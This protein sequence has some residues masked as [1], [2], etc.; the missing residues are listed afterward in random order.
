[1]SVE[2]SLGG[3]GHDALATNKL[4]EACM[5][6]GHGESSLVCGAVAVVVVLGCCTLGGLSPLGWRDLLL[7][8]TSLMGDWGFLEFYF[9]PDCIQL[10]ELGL[11]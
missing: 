3:I 11:D 1:M 9:G 8:G 2:V 4:V 7:L 6:F 5:V 10:L